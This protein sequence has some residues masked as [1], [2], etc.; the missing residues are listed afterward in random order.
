MDFLTREV[1][2]A[3]IIAV[4]LVGLALAAVRL[5]QDFSRPIPD[6][7]R[8]GQEARSTPETGAGT[9]PPGT[10]PPGTTPPG[11]DTP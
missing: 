8:S 10:T 6:P 1:F 5:Y 9:T 11:D 3:L 2:D 4:I 7:P